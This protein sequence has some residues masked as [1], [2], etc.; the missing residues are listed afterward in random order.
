MK[1]CTT[2]LLTAIFALTAFSCKRNA[3]I[4]P[5]LLDIRQICDMA[6]LECYYHNNAEVILKNKKQW[7]DYASTV[8]IGIDASL[9]SI[10]IE[11]DTVS[12]TMPKAKVLGEPKIDIDSI[13]I[14]T[15][16]GAKITND[17]Q[18]LAL[19]KANA[20]AKETTAKN[21]QILA[22][23]EIRIR[24]ILESYIQQI[25]AITGTEYKIV[26]LPY[27]AEN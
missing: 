12:I 17:D 24:K 7:I 14:L 3:A 22:N 6:V 23:A 1:K 11:D 9:L 20:N 5:N 2:L 19:Q 26:W 8:K 18:V 16:S 25:G 27:E 4:E 15:E 13:D 21:T 10:R